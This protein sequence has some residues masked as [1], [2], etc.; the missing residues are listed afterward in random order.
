M[1]EGLK[2]L[3]QRLLTEVFSLLRETGINSLPSEEYRRIVEISS[4]LVEAA[5]NYGFLKRRLAEEILNVLVNELGEDELAYALSVLKSRLKRVWFA[6]NEA[7]EL[8][9]SHA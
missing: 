3:K 1:R 6:V 2:S 7:V 8:G 9:E 4:E 5:F